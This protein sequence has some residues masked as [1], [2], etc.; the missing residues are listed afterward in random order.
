M[1]TVSS[2]K[3][4]RDIPDRLR[5]RPVEWTDERNATLKDL[6]AKG[7]SAGQIAA[8]MPP[9]SRSAILGRLHRLGLL[10]Q[11]KQRPAPI[12]REPT[13]KPERRAKFQPK[14][15]PDLAPEPFIE[16]PE[17]NMQGIQLVE[18]T[19]ATCRWPK[20]VVGADDFCFCGEPTADLAAGKP[21]C[22][23]HTRMARRV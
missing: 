16:T 1:S 11:R 23:H 4:Q 7:L 9:F 12:M 13:P 22:P 15:A 17:P 21:Y 5:G 8:Q 3:A 10:G 14:K 2:G 6:R 18:L 20:G 19:N